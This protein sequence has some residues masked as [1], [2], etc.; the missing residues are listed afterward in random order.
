[1]TTIISKQFHVT[2]YSTKLN[3]LRLRRV[4][5]TRWKI[6]PE[7]DDQGFKKVFEVETFKGVFKDSAG[8]T[9]D[10]RPKETCP[11]LNNFARMDK[12]RL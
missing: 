8:Q 7:E 4:D 9:H 10:L 11:S 1:M 12:F 2:H 6:E 3:D 5:I